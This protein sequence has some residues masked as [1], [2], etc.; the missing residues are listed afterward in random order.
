MQSANDLKQLLFNINHKSYPPI[1]LP[2]VLTSFQTISSPS[3]TSRA[4]PLP[5]HRASASMSPEKLPRFR[6]PCT[7]RTRSAS[8][9]RITCCASLHA[10]SHRIPSVQRDPAKAD[11]LA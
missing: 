4:I 8:L 3:T 5:H 2:A 11:C 7:T 9:F 10:Q 1:S 6:R